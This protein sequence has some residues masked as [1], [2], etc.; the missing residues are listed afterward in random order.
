MTSERFAVSE[1]MMPLDEALA[2][3]RARARPSI[4]TETVPL[5]AALG[6][7]LAED[8]VSPIDVPGFANSA[9]DGYALRSADTTGEGPG[10]LMP[11]AGR[12]AAGHPF[13]GRL[14]GGSVARILTGAPL[15]EGADAVIR[16][17]DCR[18]E[19]D[20]VFVPAPVPRGQDCRQAGEDIARGAAVV[21]AGTRLR[22]QELGVLAAIGRAEVAVFRRLKAAIFSTGD[23][24]RDPGQTLD[25]GCIYDS[26]RFT[27]G[28]LLETLG[29]EI[30]DLGILPD[31]LDDVRRAIAGAARGH[32]LVLT[33]GG[34]SV[35]DEDHVKA[36][37]RAEGILHF[38]KLAIKP[39]K[40]LALG[41]VVGTPFVGLPGNPV[42]VMVAFMLVVRPLVLGLMGA[43]LPPPRRFPV[44]AGFTLSRKPGRREWLR[45]RLSLEDGR[46]VAEKFP[47]ESSG[48]LSSMA[49]SEG[50]LEVPEATAE[51]RPG[52]LL[53][54]IPYDEVLR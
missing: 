42:A 32:D 6:R 37:I 34:V 33:S 26:N 4:G 47:S 17:E 12:V 48:V 23:E 18:Q 43:V 51:I 15:P 53:G 14:P 19:G 10:I 39:G 7:I 1:T 2:A 31:R 24:L 9:M 52:D 40:P 13:A 8:V 28:A 41:E 3:I 22:P 49:W 30:T 45:V 38:W 5:R 36:A 50:L 11:V 21:S 16:Q 54:F 20:L 44:A 46:L 29:A 25:P 27:A 35:G